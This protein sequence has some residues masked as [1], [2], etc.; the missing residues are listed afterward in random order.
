ME[1]SCGTVAKGAGVVTVALV[2]AVVQVRS[3]A[4]EFPHASGTTKKKKEKEEEKI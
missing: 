4:P 3:L 2:A 1:F